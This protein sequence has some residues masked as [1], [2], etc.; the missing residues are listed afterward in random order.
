MYELWLDINGSPV[1]KQTT[2]N[3]GWYPYNEIEDTI[4]AFNS[5]N[6]AWKWPPLD[7]PI[8]FV[9]T[10]DSI[11]EFSTNYPEYLI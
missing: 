4:A 5:P 1:L 2:T 8:T 11:E 9:S 6:I 3:R 10:L 7:N